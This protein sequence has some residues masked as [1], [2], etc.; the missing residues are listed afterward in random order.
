MLKLF[1]YKNKYDLGWIR[2]FI[3]ISILILMKRYAF[4]GPYKHREP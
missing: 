1:G 4:V 2:Y 3:L